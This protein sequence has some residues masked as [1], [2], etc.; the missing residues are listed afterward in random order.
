MPLKSVHWKDVYLRQT[1]KPVDSGLVKKQQQQRGDPRKS[2]PTVSHR[3]RHP[4]FRKGALRFVSRERKTTF[5]FLLLFIPAL[6]LDGLFP[7]NGPPAVAIGRIIQRNAG[8]TSD[9]HNKRKRVS[10]F[11]QQVKC[12]AAGSTISPVKTTFP[13]EQS[14]RVPRR[15]RF[16]MA[17]SIVMTRTSKTRRWFFQS[18][19]N[20]GLPDRHGS[21]KMAPHGGAPERN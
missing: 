1:E 3:F 11:R 20:H 7:T 10:T 21:L 9:A 8:D 12:C 19:C 6:Y 4:I 2:S 15:R 16:S 14:C 18:N 17:G 5:F 13:T